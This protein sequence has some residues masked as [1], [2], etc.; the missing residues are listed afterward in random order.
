MALLSR[1]DRSAIDPMVAELLGRVLGP[2]SHAEDATVRAFIAVPNNAAPRLL[3]RSDL[4]AIGARGATRLMVDRSPRATLRRAALVGALAAR[5][6]VLVPQWTIRWSSEPGTGHVIAWLEVLLGAQV[7]VSAVRLGPPRANRKPVLQISEPNGREVCWVKV[8]HSEL[9]ARLLDRERMALAALVDGVDGLHVPKALG[10]RLW[11]DGWEVLVTAP[12]PE[13]LASAPRREAV[14]SVVRSVHATS[15]VAP[16]AVAA[17]RLRTLVDHPRLSHLGPLAAAVDTSHDLLQPGAWHGDLHAG[18]F[19]LARDGVPV[20]WDWERWETDV[21]LGADLLHY[22]LQHAVVGGQPLRSA[23]EDLIS[24]SVDLL[25]VLGVPAEA[26]PLVAQDYLM[27][28]AARYV[29]DRPTPARG[30]VGDVESWI[31]PVL[32]GAMNRR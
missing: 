20:L 10:S 15:T 32:A 23:A 31:L 7:D 30:S 16:T 27:R 28:L 6:H 29:A 4:R 17:A 26:A 2:E 11:S 13:L 14:V 24:R 21:P 18:N 5:A 1:R 12:L 8:A 19:A 22:E 9:T 25:G 3:V